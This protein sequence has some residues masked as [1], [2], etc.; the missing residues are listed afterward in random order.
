MSQWLWV[1]L[2]IACY[3]TFAQVTQDWPLKSLPFTM[4][5]VGVGETDVVYL[6]LHAT[7]SSHWQSFCS[8]YSCNSWGRI[9]PCA[10]CFVM[11]TWIKQQKC[12]HNS[13]CQ[14]LHMRLLMMHGALNTLHCI[15][16]VTVLI[17]NISCGWI[18]H[19]FFC[20]VQ[21]FAPT[22]LKQLKLDFVKQRSCVDIFES[23]PVFGSL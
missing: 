14:S 4:P 5:T 2:F 12:G 8:L 23:L 13:V 19:L 22:K 16:S 9:Q 21:P 18:I 11:V 10:L 20:I 15:I 3:P 1:S 17:S 6:D 7:P